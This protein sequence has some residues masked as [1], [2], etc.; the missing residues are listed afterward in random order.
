MPILTST[1]P[2]AGPKTSG[3]WCGPVEEVLRRRYGS[4][5]HHNP[6]GPLDELVFIVLS[7]RTPE[8]PYLPAYRALRNRY[9]TL[10]ALTQA[11]LSDVTALLR[12]VRLERRKAADLQEIPHA[13]GPVR[14]RRVSIFCGSSATARPRRSSR[15]CP[16]WA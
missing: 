10:D 11:P 4:P 6:T 5:R 13:C 12:Y 15:R 14:R 16:A 7:G 3:R 8:G 2:K 1:P 9:P